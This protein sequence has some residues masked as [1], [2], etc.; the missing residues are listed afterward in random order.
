MSRLIDQ[1]QYEEDAG[2]QQASISELYQRYAPAL[3]LHLRRHCASIEDAEDLLLEIFAAALTEKRLLVLPE[4]MQRLWL[5]RVARNK[6]IDAYRQQ[7][8]CLTT[9]LE[10]TMVNMLAGDEVTPEQLI[11]RQEEQ[12][13]L[14]L[15]IQRL[16]PV[17]Q[18][19]LNLRFVQ[20]L[21]CG[22]IGPQ[23]GKSEKAI[24]SL[25]SRTLNHLRSIY[26]T[27]REG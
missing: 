10:N 26:G 24:R 14:H 22:Q 25:L 3:L 13:R 19:V 2:G 9:S 7:G 6:L 16:S 8:R 27:G 11:V 21:R 20:N 23:M 4:L 12:V 17:Q 5:W 15:A 1:D 18:Q